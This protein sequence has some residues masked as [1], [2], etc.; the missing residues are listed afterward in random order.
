MPFPPLPKED[1]QHVLEHTRSLWGQMGGGRILVTGATG[2]FGIWLLETFAHANKELGL[3]AE[4]VG[5]TRN[6]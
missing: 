1:L 3:H 5:I 4:L 6:P 2:F